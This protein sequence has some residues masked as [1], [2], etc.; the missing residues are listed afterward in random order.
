MATP[1]LIRDIMT[2]DLSTLE[3]DARLLDATLLMRSSGLRHLP[4]V[5]D[6]RPVG[7]IS[8]R[9]V[10]RASPSI[11]SKITP[12]E[13]NQMFE[14]TPVEK[15]M[16]K[17]PFTTGPDAPVKEV[18]QSMLDQKY[19]SCLVIDDEG[20]LVGIVTNTDMLRLLNDTL[21]DA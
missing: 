9:D 21:G 3:S 19:G 6:G 7:V 4:V 8:D 15:V 10:Q 16:A 1:K 12:E 17:E 13:Y 2:T 18:L 14:T 11:F 5:Q 20:K